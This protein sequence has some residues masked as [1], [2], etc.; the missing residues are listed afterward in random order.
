MRMESMVA[1][2]STGR[3]GKAEAIGREVRWQAEGEKWTCA[4]DQG[5]KTSGLVTVYGKILS[6][7]SIVYPGRNGR[8]T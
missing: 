8:S 1:Q 4:S 5:M 6:D 2:I 7:R 3:W